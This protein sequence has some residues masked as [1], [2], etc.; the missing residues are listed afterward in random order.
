MP[1]KNR[2]WL[3]SFIV[4]LTM[5]LMAES[6]SRDF[7]I[8]GNR[9]LMNGK[10]YQI[11]S[12]EMHY[13][14]IPPEYWADRLR[15]AR[16][17]G[18]NTVC[19][20]MFWNTHEPEPGQFDFSGPL[21]AA[22]YIR[23]AG[24]AGLNVIL[25]CSPYACAEWDFGGFPAR[26]LNEP[27][28]RVR[29]L[30]ARYMA[31]VARYVRRLGEELAGLQSTRG[32][33]IIALQ[34]ENEYGS[35]GND[36][37]YMAELARLYRQAGFD[38]PF[39]TAD[40]PARYLLESGSLPDALPVINFG[41]DAPRQFPRLEE[42]R[43]GIPQMCGEYWCGWFT[44]WGDARWGSADLEE[45]KK[46]VEWMLKNGKS[47][48]LYMFHGGTNFGFW[49]GANLGERYEPDITSYDYDAPLDEAGRPTR[50]FFV[51][52]DLIRK[53]GPE[54]GKLPPLPKPLSAF[55][56]PSFVPGQ[57]AALFANL[58]AAKHSPQPETMESYGQ[59]FGYILYR[60]RLIGP[61][62]GRL[63]IR[64]PHDYALVFLD[65][66]W[67]GKLDRRLG[68]SSLDLPESGANAPQLDILVE[69]LGRVNFGPGLLDRKGIT[70]Y[71]TL[72]NV[73]LMNWEV[74]N[75]PLDTPFL[76]GLRFSSL[77][78]VAGPGFFKATIILNETGDTFLDLSGWRKGVVWVNGRNLGRFWNVG[79]QRDLYLPAPWLR[80][81]EN[82]IVVF[83]LEQGNASP[84][85]GSP[86]R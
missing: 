3:F 66:K 49:A 35:Y 83:D 18:L 28:I 76:Q 5:G 2:V 26:L 15:K 22:R 29:C 4:F 64:E 82:E 77:P 47:F 58:P 25:R 38:I 69:A 30:D 10:P 14:R 57:T 80:K 13:A 71:V 20:Y 78:K 85:K 50:K 45:Q 39:T 68:E 23:L 81:G 7:R 42:F 9:F 17:M 34:V 1:K 21:D 33:P 43:P 54:Q 55:A 32:G 74:F 61:K 44:H 62:K 63:V 40:G 36:R 46:D 79:P 19:T 65:G 73:T 31:A 41:G 37:E 53:F 75:L 56:I 12:G 59:Y 11:I 60:T 52:R 70:Q 24:E 27:G 6:K 48:S 51:F 86:S 8:E 67:I 84:I 72:N 16:A